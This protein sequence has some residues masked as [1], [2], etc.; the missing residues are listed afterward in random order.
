MKRL[1]AAFALT[2][3]LT[4]S[5][6]AGDIYCGRTS[7]LEE[8]GASTGDIDCGVTQTVVTLMLSLL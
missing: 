6:Y 8:V 2:C 3:A 1:L 5:A 4:M 7:Q